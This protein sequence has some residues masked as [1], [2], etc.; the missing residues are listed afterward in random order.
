MK[1]QHWEKLQQYVADGKVIKNDHPSLPIS[2]YSY[3]RDCQY[4]GLWDE[5]TIEARGL[6]LDK[7]GNMVA[8]S[9][10]KFF[11]W[12]ETD[13][14]IPKFEHAYIQEKVDGS[15]GILFYYAGEWHLATKKSF[16]SDQGVK[17]LDIIKA[18]YNLD[19]FFKEFVYVGEIIYPE[20]RIV[21]D[22]GQ[23]ER[24]IFLSLFLEGRELNWNTALSIFSGSEIKEE[25]IVKSHLILNEEDI[26]AKLSR[27]EQ[28]IENEEGYVFRFYPGN[29]RVKLKFAEY[30]RLHRLL[31][32]FSNLDIWR[33]L[34]EGKGVTEF[35]ERVPDEFDRWVR[36]QVDDLQSKYDKIQRDCR[37]LVKE[38][39]AVP[40]KDFAERIKDFDS[41]LKPVMFAMYDGKDHSKIIWR[42][43]KPVYQ[44]P[45][46]QKE[47]D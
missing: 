25:D 36:S 21:V 47:E 7:D 41:T 1:Y 22:Y 13:K 10:P 17:G 38:N 8:R 16:K 45:F 46:W 44:K 39:F 30:V 33:S 29:Y 35:L 6:I 27:S 37:F 32:S 43:L 15:L 5:V 2:I 26:K 20:N 18:K 31:T 23:D 19:R 42:N 12:E 11:N 40:K 9:F 28:E 34:S 4:A 14:R 24:F 3:S